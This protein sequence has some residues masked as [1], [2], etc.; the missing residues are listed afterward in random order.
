MDA[1]GT[2]GAARGN[3]A[4]WARC[5]LNSGRGEGGRSWEVVGA[6]PP[7]PTTPCLVLLGLDHVALELPV[8]AVELHDLH[9]LDREAVG[10]RGLHAHAGQ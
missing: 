8:L 10:G 6:G 4:P 9:V 7:A 3:E 1:R 5:A 2:A